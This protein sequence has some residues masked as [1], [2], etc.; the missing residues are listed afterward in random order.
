VVFSVAAVSACGSS[1]SK[2]SGS[3]GS[4][5]STAAS[6]TTASSASAPGSTATGAPIVVGTICSCSGAQGAV[7]AATGKTVEAWAS[8]VNAAGGI[9]GHPVKVIVKDDGSN[10]AKGLQYAK[11]LIESDHVVAIVGEESLTTG[12]WAPYVTGRGV[13]VVGGLPTDTPFLTSADFYPIGSGLPVVTYGQLQL[14]KDAGKKMFGTM[15]CAESPICAQIVPIGKALAKLQGI[16]FTGEPISATSPSYT[17]PCLALKGQGVDA[18]WVADNSTV[19]DRVVNACP[20]QGYKPQINASL[21]TIGT[22]ALTNPNFNGAAIA[23]STAL[24]TDTSQPAVKQFIDATKTYAP[25]VIGTPEFGV[26][27]LFAWAG[28]QLFA[29]A[30][31]AAKLTPSSTPADVKKGLYAL[32]NETLDG[33]AGPL[34]FTPGKPAFPA[35]YYAVTIAHGQFVASGGGKPICLTPQQLASV[36]AALKG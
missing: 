18:L 14:A 16:G 31:A 34:N 23:S 33:L 24:Y 25:G 28:G 29:K 36:G 12:S 4:S 15:Y 27:N 26:N 21:T 6:G 1:S 5:S 13:P 2:S 8:T 7:L 10:P 11:E 22:E 3:N 9:N 20:Q 35:C 32:K 17:A 30:A 19:V